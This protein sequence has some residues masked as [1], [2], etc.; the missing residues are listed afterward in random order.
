VTINDL[1]LGVLIARGSRPPDQ[2]PA[3]D[4]AGDGVSNDDLVTALGRALYGCP[5]KTAAGSTGMGALVT[6]Y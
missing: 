2:C 5:S 3:M 4:A 6:G 1:V